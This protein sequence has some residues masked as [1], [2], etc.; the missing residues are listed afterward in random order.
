MNQQNYRNIG[1]ED[2][3]EPNLRN[4]NMSVAPGS[5]IARE[6]VEKI[7]DLKSILGKDLLAADSRWTLFVAAALSYRYDSQL[8]PLPPKYVINGTFDIDYLVSTIN[9]TP[10]LGLILGTINE[11]NYDELDVDVVELLHW[12]LISEKDTTLRTIKE[13]EFDLVLS[14]VPQVQSV[15]RPTHIFEVCPSPN[16]KAESKFAKLQ[17]GYTTNFA[18]HG[19]KLDSF[20]SILNHGL[21][22]HMCKNA[23][24]GEGIY[25]SSELSVSLNFSPNGA[26][27]GASKCGPILSCVAIC[28]Y[29]EH[30]EHLQCHVKT[31]KKS[32]VPEKYFVITNNE[33]VRVRYLLFFGNRSSTSNLLATKNMA[34]SWM[35]KN[36]YFLTICCYTLLLASIGIANSGNGMYIRHVISKK[37][38]YLLDVLRKTF[39][40]D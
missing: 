18:F 7:C 1:S 8:R 13:S 36:K 5:H 22:Q 25:L 17:E 2:P 20:N 12:V 4:N 33:I 15:A 16:S 32:K 39:Y 40:D 11:G 30:P 3:G 38:N 29:I 9:D 19:S 34:I 10:A 14:K 31:D 26:A 35:S 23:L 27:W 21:Q 24:F 28:E 37:T 6:Y